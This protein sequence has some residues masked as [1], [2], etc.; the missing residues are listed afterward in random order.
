MTD[1]AQAQ[2]D[3]RILEARMGQELNDLMQKH[4]VVIEECTVDLL[5]VTTLDDD[6]PKYTARVLLRAYIR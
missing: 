6:R 1:I 3:L 2:N 4:D 5:D